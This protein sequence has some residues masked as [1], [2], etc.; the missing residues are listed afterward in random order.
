[1]IGRFVGGEA[2]AFLVGTVFGCVWLDVVLCVGVG[3][4]GVQWC[5]EVGWFGWFAIV[6]WGGFDGFGVD[7]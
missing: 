2:V 3:G 7:P 4:R 5:V 6:G 1:V